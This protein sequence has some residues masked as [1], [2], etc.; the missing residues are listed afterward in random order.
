V[1]F[2][3][4]NAL[5]LPL[6]SGSVQCIVTSPPY[7]ALRDYGVS[8]QLG[9]ER[10]PDCLGW[11][12]GAP[13]GECYVCHMVQ[14]F[15]EC[16]R[17]LREDGVCWMNLGDSYNGSSQ[18]GSDTPR[19]SGEQARLRELHD[20]QRNIKTKVAGLKPKDLIGIPWRVALAL[21]ADGW[22]LRSDVIWAKPN[23]MP[24]SVTD[25]P[26]KAHEYLFLLAK[27]PRYY[28]DCDAI[29]EPVKDV[30]LQRLS[31]PNFEAQQGGPKDPKSGNRSERRTLENLKERYAKENVWTDRQDGWKTWDKP[32]RNRRTVWEIATQPT[33]EAHF[34][35]FPEKLVEPCI[36]AGTSARGCCP[37]CGAPWERIIEKTE[38]IDTSS[39]G[40]RFD[41]GKTGI[42]GAGRV[43][44]GER[45]TNA[46]TGWRPSCGHDA[47][48]VPCRVLDPF[49]GSGTT[50]RVAIRLGRRFVGTELSFPYIRDISKHRVNNLQPALAE[51]IA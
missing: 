41:T 25:R 24:E 19:C 1:I 34:A 33:S 49:S 6:A 20:S 26:T 23:P 11:A 48:P 38:E 39:K 10:V 35:T 16:K 17:V 44:E 31:Q 32:G 3:N 7:W 18:S 46:T 14:V 50:G 5:S 36:L 12:T 13:C 43:Q 22:Y 40:S 29:R 51:A 15:R 37:V 8:G 2:V 45:F 4:A 28:Y 30:T 21:Q 47:E 27:Q 42:N 9:L